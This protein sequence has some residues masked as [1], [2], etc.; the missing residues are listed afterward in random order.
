VP[1]PDPPCPV[2]D[3]RPVT[4][5][6]H[7]DEV[8]DPYAWLRDRDDPAVVAHL[9]AENA[10][11]EAAMAHTAGAA[12]P[13]VRG[14]PVAGAGDRPVGAGATPGPWWYFGRTSE[15]SQYGCTAGCRPR[16]ERLTLDDA[17]PEIEPGVP[18]PGEQVLLDENVMAGDSDYFALG[19]FDVSLDH[20]WLAYSTDYDGSEKY[21]LRVRDLD[22]GED[23]ADEIP[24]VTYGTAWSDDAR[25]LFYVRPDDAMR[26]H[27]VWRHVI[28]TPVDDD[29]LVFEE[30]DEHF[31]VSLGRTKDDRF[32]VVH[33][34]SKVTDE[35]WVLP[36]DDPFAEWRVVAPR[37]Q[38]VEYSVEHHGDR[39][40]ILT[41]ADGAENFK[42]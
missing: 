10:H 21:T 19:A 20:R 31:F 9:E 6:H 23:L 29:V 12:G 7:G 13:A 5:L 16:A 3:A 25:V 22:T 28:G 26:P 15:G 30:P 1:S 37:E 32:V 8:V 40:V 34:G 24:E 14:D 17:P 41:N 39:F 11:T 36:G 27:Q 18:F 35:T 4:R 33:L 2:P 38:G 42:W